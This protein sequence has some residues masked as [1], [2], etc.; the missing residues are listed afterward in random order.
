MPSIS[1]C[2]E[3]HRD[4]TLPDLA[5]HGQTLRCPLCDAQFPA[6]RL[7]ADS[8][9]FPPTAI[10]VSP[11]DAPAPS[12]SDEIV[13]RPPAGGE[14]DLKQG[15]PWPMTT[16]HDTGTREDT[17]SPSAYESDLNETEAD[18]R[19]AEESD[20]NESADDESDLDE[21][22]LDQ[23]D[24]DES[25]VE[26]PVGGADSWPAASAEDTGSEASADY[27]AFG[28][29]AA[30]MRTAPRTRR[31]ASLLGVLGQL[32]GMALG[33]VVGLA[34]GYWVLLWVGGAQTDFLHLRGKLPSWLVP[35]RRHN[36]AG[37]NLPL[38]SQRGRRSGQ[39]KRTLGDVVRDPPGDTQD[40]G[41]TSPRLAE[42][43]AEDRAETPAEPTP[44][45]DTG[46]PS[47]ALNGLVE[48]LPLG[49]PAF[50]QGYLGPRAFKARTV[51]ELTAVLE[52]ADRALRCPHCQAP[53]AVKL[54]ASTAAATETTTGELSNPQRCD[55]CRGKPPA[56]L[57]A[58]AFERLCD[59][60]E[61]VTFVQFDE[62]DPRRD[63]CR[64][65]AEAIA[66][67]VGAQRER[68]ETAGRLAGQ[69]LDNS[70]RQ[71][72]G[73]LLAGTVL[74]AEHEGDLF[75]IHLMLFGCGK[76]VT[77]ISRQPPDPPVERRDRL[78][79]L[80][81]IIDSPRDNLAGY[82]GELPQVV[83]GGLPLKLASAA[84]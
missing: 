29:Q 81:S 19:G 23:P 74:R 25:D 43:S 21:S 33:G 34:L 80:G 18:E 48:R 22:D 11:S 53:P 16:L 24:L 62:D 30:T 75:A 78:V 84:R 72:N 71:S 44:P 7:M 20:L 76:P 1:S 77:L 3:C 5:D 14:A 49:G 59:L 70:Q 56:N 50:P 65:A 4:L 66:L 55:H 73:I 82:A 38:A 12:V 57:T 46:S 2:P 9:P 60:A 51:A 79:V 15:Q 26:A 67:A 36:D 10:V 64:E 83:W 17:G 37:Q 40:A 61:A 58:A 69:R 39:P 13:D 31:Q 35:S 42:P 45:S 47:A 8:V 28:R 63:E 54:A 32:V 6:E 27:A 52:K 41:G 68:T